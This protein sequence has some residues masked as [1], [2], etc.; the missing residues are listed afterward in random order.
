MSRTEKIIAVLLGIAIAAPIII[1]ISAGLAW[2]AS[3]IW[4]SC[5]VPLTGAP[6][7]GFWSAWGILF[8]LSIIGR[9]LFPS[10]S[11]QGR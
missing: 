7:I 6:Q 9:T 4:N 8:L 1:G 11:K 10:S 3:A 5:V 2:A